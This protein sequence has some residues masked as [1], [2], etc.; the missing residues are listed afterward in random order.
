MRKWRS[1]NGPRATY[2]RLA[3][4]FFGAERPGMVEVI[5]KVID[6]NTSGTQPAIQPSYSSTGDQPAQQQHFIQPNPPPHQGGK[7]INRVKPASVHQFV[8]SWAPPTSIRDREKFKLLTKGVFST[9][10]GVLALSC[11]SLEAA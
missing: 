6:P 10:F 8:Q 4:C 5:C 3:M 2:R 1:K 7:T 11:S 9:N